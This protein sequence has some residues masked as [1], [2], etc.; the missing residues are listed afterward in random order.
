ME[1]FKDGADLITAGFKW[2]S[3]ILAVTYC[4]VHAIRGTGFR[5]LYLAKEEY[6]PNPN[7]PPDPEPHTQTRIT[8]W[9]CIGFVFHVHDAT[10]Q[11]QYIQRLRGLFYHN[12]ADTPRDAPDGIYSEAF[13]DIFPVFRYRDKK[14]RTTVY[15]ASLTRIDLVQPKRES[16]DCTN[17]A[18]NRIACALERTKG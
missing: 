18:L 14:L 8:D 4:L 5:C 2:L 17:D 16:R 15:H 12:F 1:F 9:K 10:D 13:H 11:G 7:H 6:G 3:A